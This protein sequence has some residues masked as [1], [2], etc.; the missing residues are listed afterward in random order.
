M[1]VDDER[2]VDGLVV[3]EQVADE[4]VVG[5]RTVDERAAGADRVDASSA[6]TVDERPVDP[7][8]AARRV[9]APGTSGGTD[10]QPIPA[11]ETLGALPPP[12]LAA[13]RDVRYRFPSRALPGPPPLLRVDAS[14]RDRSP[15]RLGASVRRTLGALGEAVAP[16]RDLG[17]SPAEQTIAFVEAFIPYMPR[18]LAHLFPVGLRFFEWAPYLVGPLRRRLSRLGVTERRRVLR[19]LGHG[20]QPIREAINAVQSLCACAIYDHPRMHEVLGYS[21]QGY[22]DEKTRERRR[23]FGASEAW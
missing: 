11:K 14:R 2:A 6:Q 15:V 12:R 16:S 22:L 8:S 10:P 17:F 19:R 21:P 7:V 18:P 4:R 1:L 5:D 20:P 13:A 23:R 9:V 3:D